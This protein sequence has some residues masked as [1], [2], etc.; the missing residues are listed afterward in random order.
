MLRT[1]LFEGVH[2]TAVHTDRFKS[3]LV[4]VNFLGACDERE[5]TVFAM[6]PAVMKNGCSKVPYHQKPQQTTRIPVSA[7]T[8]AEF[9]K[10]RRGGRC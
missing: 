1:K 3:S 9:L 5:T 4:S 7:G 8:C 2:L 10:A 6:L